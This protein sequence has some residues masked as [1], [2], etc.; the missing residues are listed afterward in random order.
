M[1]SRSAAA[2]ATAVLLVFATS[3][4][5]DPNPA[6]NAPGAPLPVDE[7]LTLQGVP[8]RIRWRRYENYLTYYPSLAQIRFHE[9]IPQ[10]ERLLSD[11]ALLG[12]VLGD[13]LSGATIARLDVD[14]VASGDDS[15]IFKTV[16]SLQSKSASDKRAPESVAFAMKWN[17]DRD[18]RRMQALVAIYEAAAKSGQ[19]ATLRA[20]RSAVFY[21]DW[22]AGPTVIS[23]MQSRPLAGPE[24]KGI[25]KAWAAVGLAIAGAFQYDLY[26]DDLYAGNILFK[27]SADTPEFLVVDVGRKG[28]KMSPYLFLDRMTTHYM[29]PTSTKWPETSEPGERPPVDF[30]LEGVAEGLGGDAAWDFFM[31]LLAHPIVAETVP[32]RHVRLIRFLKDRYRLKDEHVILDHIAARRL[33][34]ALEY[35]S[36]VGYLLAETNPK[37]SGEI[38]AMFSEEEMRNYPD[39]DTL[40]AL[41]DALLN[42]TP[43]QYPEKPPVTSAF[44]RVENIWRILRGDGPFPPLKK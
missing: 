41:Y 33:R 9:L 3:A 13:R 24:L 31:R 38:Y 44:P 27:N 11:S 28:E 15:D 16:F 43:S 10:L 29:V 23:V 39:P 22:V 26:P 6:G 30:L 20:Q 4:S 17:R 35:P 21:Q 40:Q 2:V 36:N 19:L 32:A 18:A 7:S 34:N 5:C 25:A 14:Y 12:M 8:V 42:L 37:R 1:S